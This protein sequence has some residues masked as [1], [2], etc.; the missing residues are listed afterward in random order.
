M[1]GKNF[2]PRNNKAHNGARSLENVNNFCS[3][4]RY[5]HMIPAPSIDMILFFVV[6]TLLKNVNCYAT[7]N[8]T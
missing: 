4:K 2:D 5:G 8:N 3:R 7:Q 1:K 6:K